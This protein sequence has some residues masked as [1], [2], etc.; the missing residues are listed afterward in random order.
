MVNRPRLPAI[1]MSRL[2]M[3]SLRLKVPRMAVPELT[4]V[5]NLETLDND[6]PGLERRDPP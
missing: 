3:D 6:T 5:I 2:P 4:E 1:R